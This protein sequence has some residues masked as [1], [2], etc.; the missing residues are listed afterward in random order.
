[1]LLK[2]HNRVNFNV[3]SRHVRRIGNMIEQTVRCYSEQVATRP[4]VSYLLLVIVCFHKPLFASKNVTNYRY[5][6][7][8]TEPS[9]AVL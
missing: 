4:I 6:T 2:S 9:K 3:V 7:T 1:M 8:K 5:S